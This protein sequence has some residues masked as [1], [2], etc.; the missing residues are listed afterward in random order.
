MRKFP[1]NDS[2]EMA[3][4]IHAVLLLVIAAIL[5]GALLPAAINTTA[6]STT[7]AFSY[8][9]GMNISGNGSTTNG[10][11]STSTIATWDAIPILVAVSMLVLVV[12]FM[13]RFLK[14]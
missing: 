11:W 3:T 4:M 7:G 1:R 9:N 13:M 6:R 10:A 2:G 12:F 5:I 14:G 8:V